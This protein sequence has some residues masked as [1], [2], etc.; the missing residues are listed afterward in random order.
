MFE[1]KE[2]VYK[3]FGETLLHARLDAGMS[4]ES[5]AFELGLS[6]NTI[7]KW[8]HGKSQPDICQLLGLFATLDLDPMDY[9][10]ETVRRA[11]ELYNRDDGC[12]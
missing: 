2:A 6:V 4:Q 5:V 3:L 8:E 9:M 10:P 12:S 11:K 7:Y 1:R